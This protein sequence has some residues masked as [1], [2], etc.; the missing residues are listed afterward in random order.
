MSDQR[1][2]YWVRIKTRDAGPMQPSV[3]LRYAHPPFKFKQR[4]PFIDFGNT[5]R[6]FVTK[7]N[8]KEIE[9]AQP[10]RR[11]DAAQQIK[12]GLSKTEKVTNASIYIRRIIV[13]IV[14]LISGIG[15]IAGQAHP[16]EILGYFAIGAVV[17]GGIVWYM[18]KKK[19]AG[20]V[21]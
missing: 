19:A 7:I 10:E 5:L 9:V 14:V 15:Y 13:L 4:Q 17:A 1:G 12:T 11:S 20:K 6:R 2:N 18:K 16:G 3:R 21:R 8:N